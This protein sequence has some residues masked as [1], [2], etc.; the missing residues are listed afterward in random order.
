MERKYL[1]KIIEWMN[2]I[3]RKPLMVWGARQV[4]KSYLV[5]ELF[6]KRYYKD[7]FLKIDLSDDVD[8]VN[9]AEKN[10]SLDL[11][12]EYIE[13]HYH[14]IPDDKHLLFFDEAQEC[15]SIVKMM[16]HFCEKRRDIPVIVSGSLVRLRIHR[17]SKKTKNKFLFPVGKMNQLYVFPMTFDEFMLNYDKNKYEY[18]KKHFEEQKPIDTI[19]HNE[20][21]DDFKNYMFIGGMPEVVDTFL[22]YKD[23]KITA[24]KKAQEKMQEIYD[25]YLDDMGLYQTSTESIIRTRL[26]YNDIF[27]QLNKENK[28]FKIVN[29][30]K[31]EKNRDVVNPYFWL[32]M[33][34]VV[35]QSFCLKEKVATPLLRDEDSLFRLYLSDVGM[36]TYQSGHNY[37]S[38]LMDKNSVLTGI[39]YENYVAC[40]LSSRRIG[41]FY[42]KGKRNSEL[43]FLICDKENVIPIDTKKRKGELSSL[44]EFRQHNK[45]TIA[46]KVSEN[47]F[48]YDQTRMINTI[49]YYYFSFFLNDF[50]NE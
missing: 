35:Y 1:T 10:S 29:T 38:F 41:L 9:Y 20:L 12:L 11:I 47:Q 21:I 8:F 15:P 44:D 26:I 50:I 33:A 40:E 42:W 27:R 30:I 22:K 45:K 36:F 6:L 19:I 16:K 28:N 39:Y 17:D 4:G 49:P 37:E 18:I 34:G 46:I 3:D 2:D 13:L 43:E 31:K 24:F 14:F 25:N 48:G 7:M 32:T 23:N 5:E